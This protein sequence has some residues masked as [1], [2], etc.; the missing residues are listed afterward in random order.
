M[1]SVRLIGNL[2]AKPEIKTFDNNRKMA[3]LR[4]ATNE[5]YKNQ[6]GEWVSETH[7]H[8]LV[9]WG[10]QA[11]FFEEY[12]DK[13]SEVSIEGKLITRTYN[14]KDGN[15][16]WITEVVVNEASLVEKTETPA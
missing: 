15:Q 12:T 11:E 3:R 13:G 4:M 6:K 1:N 10:K 7:W 8:T 5:S 14:D 16:K 2:G 9:A